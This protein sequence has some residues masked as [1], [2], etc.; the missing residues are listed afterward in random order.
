MVTFE[1]FGKVMGLIQD[2]LGKYGRCSGL[3]IWLHNLEPYEFNMILDAVENEEKRRRD[4]EKRK[5]T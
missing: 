3:N 5:N 4:D 2:N 1:E